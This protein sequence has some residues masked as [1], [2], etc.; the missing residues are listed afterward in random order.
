ML[1]SGPNFN[2]LNYGKK[3]E[4]FK[5]WKKMGRKETKFHGKKSQIWSLEREIGGKSPHHS[6]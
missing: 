4:I 2:Q 5:L 1:F 3:D 6:F